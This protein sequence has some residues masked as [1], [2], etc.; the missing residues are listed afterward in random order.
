MKRITMTM[1]ASLILASGCWPAPAIA[2]RYSDHAAGD[3]HDWPMFN[4]DPEGTRWNRAEHHLGRSNVAGLKVKWTFATQAVVAGTPAVVGDR[5]YA[6]D[7]S[8]T[9]YALDRHGNLFWSNQVAGPVTASVLVTGRSVIFGDIAG[10]VYGLDVRTGALRWKIRPNPHPAASIFGSAT[11]IGGG[12]AIGVASIE[13]LLAGNPSYTPSFRGSLVLLDPDTGKFHWQ[14]YTI[15][16]K[17]AAAGASGAGIRSKP[18]GDAKGGTIYA[19][20]GN[21]YTEPTTGMSDAILAVNAENGRIPWVNQ[22]T[23]D[24]QWNFRFPN[25][26]NHVD[27]D[28]GDSAQ[29]YHLRDGRRVVGAGQKSGFYHVLDA[30]TGGAINQVQVEVGGELSGLFADSA[31]ARGVAFANTSN[32]PNGFVGGAPISGSLVA[33]DASRELWRFKTATPN[34]SGV[35]VANDVVYFQSA[36]DGTL[37]ALDA[38]NGNLLARVVTGGQSSGPSVSRG[39]VYLGTGNALGL[40]ADLQHPG[41]GTIIALGVD[42]N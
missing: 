9:I 41:P 34:L 32:W 13:E 36:L 18:T 24:D 2:Q 40:V 12:V 33:G 6:G 14:T 10:F 5:I 22:R 31:V 30:S 19:T 35:A 21:N 28:F 17:D 42:D 15:S 11:P 20:T 26:G 27:F 29:V 38:C 25:T 39:R 23:A 37:Y 8:G 4:H 1:V 16:D 3:A 7:G